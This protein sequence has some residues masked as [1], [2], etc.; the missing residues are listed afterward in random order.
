MVE[1][2]PAVEFEPGSFSH[3]ARLSPSVTS[4]QNPDAWREYWKQSLA[5]SQI[6][7]LDPIDHTWLVRVYGHHPT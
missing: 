1:L 4:E 7:E 6:T 3:V 2:I 5:D